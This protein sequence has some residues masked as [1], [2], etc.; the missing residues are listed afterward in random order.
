M[1]DFWSHKDVITFS[2]IICHD[3]AYEK[4]LCYLNTFFMNKFVHL[5]YSSTITRISEKVKLAMFT[6]PVIFK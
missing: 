2:F 6:Y 4:F 1:V 5:Y 3:A